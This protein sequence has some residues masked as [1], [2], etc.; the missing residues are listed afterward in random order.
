MCAQVWKGDKY[1]N[2]MWLHKRKDISLKMITARFMFVTKIVS[3]L[4]QLKTLQTLE[5]SSFRVKSH[6]THTHW[7]L[8]SCWQQAAVVLLMRSHPLLINLRFHLAVNVGEDCPVFD[9]LFEFCQLSAG[10][11]AGKSKN[12]STLQSR[13]FRATS[14]PDLLHNITLHCVTTLDILT[15]RCCADYETRALLQD[16]YRVLFRQRFSNRMC[17]I[18]QFLQLH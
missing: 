3:T 8:Y 1:I 5:T 13:Q 17:H 15:A 9:G 12:T 18:L 4:H 16:S 11:S 7:E 10:G 2:L 14:S 6:W